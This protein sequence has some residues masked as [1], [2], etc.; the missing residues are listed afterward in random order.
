MQ[1]FPN[2]RPGQTRSRPTQKTTETQGISQ[3]ATENFPEFA[4]P[5]HFITF[6]RASLPF[7]ARGR[8]PDSLDRSDGPWA[9]RIIGEVRRQTP[10][11]FRTLWQQTFRVRQRP[12]SAD[13]VAHQLPWL[14]PSG[15]RD[16]ADRCVPVF[17][18]LQG[19]RGT[20]QAEG[21]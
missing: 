4:S 13:R 21:R 8:T 3:G 12:S 1:P 5:N 2:G 11:P 16:Y 18:R 17:L 10:R 9:F 7:R 6:S 14:W 15:G 19:V 20:P